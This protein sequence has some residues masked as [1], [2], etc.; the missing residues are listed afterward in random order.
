MKKNTKSLL[1]LLLAVLMLC[2]LL[3]GCGG[4]PEAPEAPAVTAEPENTGDQEVKEPA[5]GTETTE[6]EDDY[7][8]VSSTVELVDAIAPNARIMIDAGDYNMSEYIEIIP[9]H[10]SFDIDKWD[11]EHEYV[12]IKDVFDGY[13]L[14][15]H[16]ADHLTIVGA[17]GDPKD[18]KLVVEPRYATALTFRDCRDINLAGLTI[19]HT[20]EGDC[21]GDVIELYGCKNVTL[22]AMDLFGCGVHGITACFTKDL[23][24][25]NSFIHD[26]E[27]GP[28][29][30]EQCVGKIEFTGCTLS[31]NGVGGFYDADDCDMS[32]TDCVFGEWESNVLYFREDI[33]FDNCQ[34]SEITSYPDYSGG[35][36]EEVSYVFDPDRLKETTLDEDYLCSNYWVGYYQVNMQSG[37]SRDLPAY[38][39]G[40]ADEYESIV[41]QFKENGTGTLEYWDGEYDFNWSVLSDGTLSVETGDFNVYGHYCVDDVFFDDYDLYWLRIELF[42]DVIWMY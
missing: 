12:T 42:N 35:D 14:V 38:I 33:D 25:K 19:G 24:V 22:D 7:I 10:D 34:F 13:E 26:C 40:G 2:A 6:P 28:V 37:E 29:D 4:K 39:N 36:Y 11:A 9:A 18:T 16:D 27:Y 21:T 30:I 5:G 23:S 17:T 3:S 41:M 32:F 31:D 8:H 1:A 15:I 20:E